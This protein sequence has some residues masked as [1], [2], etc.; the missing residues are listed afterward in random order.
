MLTARPP[1]DENHPQSN[2]V[3]KTLLFYIHCRSSEDLRRQ[4]LGLD[5]LSGRLP[6][7]GFRPRLQLPRLGPWLEC[8]LDLRERGRLV[9]R[10]NALF[11]EDV[12]PF[13]VRGKYLRTLPRTD[14][15]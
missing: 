7:R 13:L 15:R 5:G 8:L 9:S 14:N 10:D 4:R 6:T 3:R 1:D 12:E 11:A 2:G